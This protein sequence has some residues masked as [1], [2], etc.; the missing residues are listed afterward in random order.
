V[1]A[2]PGKVSRSLCINH[3]FSSFLCLYRTGDSG[4]RDVNTKASSSCS[5]YRTQHESQTSARFSWTVLK[6]MNFFCL[7]TPQGLH[8]WKA[9]S[10][11]FSVLV[12][13]WTFLQYTTVFPDSGK[14]ALFWLSCH[15]FVCSLTSSSRDGWPLLQDPLANH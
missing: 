2:S 5:S 3:L 6:A 15:F 14:P 7:P 13:F 9:N 1:F 11:P 10:S 12:P 4:Y 8:P